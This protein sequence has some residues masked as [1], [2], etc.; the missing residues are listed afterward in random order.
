VIDPRDLPSQSR[1]SAVGYE[2]TVTFARPLLPTGRQLPETGM[3]QDGGEGVSG[4]EQATTI[5]T[6]ADSS[7]RQRSRDCLL[8]TG[9]RKFDSTQELEEHIASVHMSRNR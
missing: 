9:G 5:L 7:Q 1:L 2:P 3:V 6:H 8:C 4:I